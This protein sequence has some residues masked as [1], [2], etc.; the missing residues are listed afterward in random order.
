MTSAMSRIDQNETSSEK[1]SG[2]RVS[3][4]FG[5]LS[6]TSLSDVT[7]PPKWRKMC[8]LNVLIGWV[9]LVSPKSCLASHER[10]LMSKAT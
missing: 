2:S 9:A 3:S 4:E 7:R 6:F 10:S 8:R 5:L 1:F